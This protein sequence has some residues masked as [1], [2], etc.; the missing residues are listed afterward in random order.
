MVGD[1]DIDILTARNCGVRSIGCTFGFKPYSLP[2]A[3]PDYLAHTPKDWLRILN[4]E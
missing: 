2:P 3:N 1:T 4:M